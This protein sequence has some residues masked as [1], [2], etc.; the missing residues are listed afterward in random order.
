MSQFSYPT[1]CRLIPTLF[2]ISIYYASNYF[3]AFEVYLAW[4]HGTV[5]GSECRLEHGAT[6]GH[7]VLATAVFGFKDYHY[8][9]LVLSLPPKV[10]CLLQFCG[11]NSD[12]YVE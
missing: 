10:C 5:R 3:A 12:A 6:F 9:Q 4:S 7:G 11:Y 1:S 2:Y 8:Q